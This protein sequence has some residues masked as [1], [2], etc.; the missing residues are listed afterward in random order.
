M[1]TSKLLRYRIA[2]KYE[3]DHFIEAYSPEEAIEL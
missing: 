1:A 2:V 3:S